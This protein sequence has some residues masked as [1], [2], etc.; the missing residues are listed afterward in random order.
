MGAD[1]PIQVGP[2]LNHWPYAALRRLGP[3]AHGVIRFGLLCRKPGA[4]GAFVIKPDSLGN[5]P[6]LKNSWVLIA[7]D[8][9]EV[10]RP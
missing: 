8:G 7:A 1:S 3:D 2:E 5:Y 10:A 4:T 6:R 9:S